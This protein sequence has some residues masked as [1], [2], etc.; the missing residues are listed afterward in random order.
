MYMYI[1]KYRDVNK[2]F[3]FAFCESNVTEMRI[4]FVLDS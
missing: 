2:R 1:F 3:A 4:N